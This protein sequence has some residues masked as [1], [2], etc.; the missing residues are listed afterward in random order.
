M[1]L[2]GDEAQLAVA[3]ESTFKTRP[4]T[5]DQQPG[6]GVRDEIDFTDEESLG[7]LRMMGGDRSYHDLVKSDESREVSLPT[8]FQ[9]AK[10][11]EFVLGS[12]SEDTTSAGSA[13]YTH[14][15][16]QA[17]GLDTL[18]AE[19]A[20]FNT[21]GGSDRVVTL[22]G[23]MVSSFELVSSP[24]N[25]AVQA[26]YDLDVAAIP[27]VN[28]NT[29]DS[30]SL[31][32]TRPFK[33][34]DLTTYSFNGSDIPHISEISLSIENEVSELPD[35]G[36]YEA[37]D[38]VPLNIDYSADVTFTPQ[39]IQ[40]YQEYESGAEGDLIFKWERGTNDAVEFNFTNARI[41]SPGFSMPLEDVT[42]AEM[43][44]TAQDVTVT[45]TDGSATYGLT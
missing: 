39:G 25:D 42:E 44:F 5:V 10:M 12:L 3:R 35:N 4:T 2:K 17:S 14:E 26:D 43:T 24:D 23:C 20:A 30:T 34:Q 32:A 37:G 22:L 29:N 8:Y 31:I 45:V 6:G 38:L 7:K 1:V 21:G 41:E 33:H 28:T 9:N 15:V 11:L 18:T 40:F 13:P 16:T 36:S 27:D 19:Y